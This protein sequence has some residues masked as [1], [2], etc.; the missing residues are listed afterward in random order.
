MINLGNDLQNGFK[1]T[2]KLSTLSEMSFRHEVRGIEVIRACDRAMALHPMSAVETHQTTT[3]IVPQ[4]IANGLNVRRHRHD[5]KGVEAT[6]ACKHGAHP[7]GM[8]APTARRLT[9]ACDVPKMFKT[10]VHQTVEARHHACNK[11]VLNKT[12]PKGCKAVGKVRGKTALST[13]ATSV[14]DQSHVQSWPQEAHVDR[15]QLEHTDSAPCRH[16]ALAQSNAEP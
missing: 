3:Q 16:S 6:E 11:E 10:T 12:V 15:R 8:P 7:T 5:Q 13:F 1:T 14:R 9:E 4:T 2:L